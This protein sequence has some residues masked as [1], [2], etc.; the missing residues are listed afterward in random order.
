MSSFAN[1]LNFYQDNL[2]ALT[3]I[4]L[5]THTNRSV[6]MT[7]KEGTSKRKILLQTLR[8]CQKKYVIFGSTERITIEVGGDYLPNFLV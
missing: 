2:Q 7:G 4:R 5:I 8:H 6:F 1:L 3:A